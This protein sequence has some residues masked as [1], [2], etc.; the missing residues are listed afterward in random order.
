MAGRAEFTAFVEGPA[1][2]AGI[3]PVAARWAT[4]QE[5]IGSWEPN[6]LDP[7]LEGLRDLARQV[8]GPDQH[9]YVWWWL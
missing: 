1:D 6:E 9:M 7:T 4:A 5:W 8:N 2:P 3:P